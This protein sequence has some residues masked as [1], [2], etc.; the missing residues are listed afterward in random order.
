M[1][2][3]LNPEQYA[4]CFCCVSDERVIARIYSEA[5]RIIEFFSIYVE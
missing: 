1:A 5:A 2:R 3:L 4:S